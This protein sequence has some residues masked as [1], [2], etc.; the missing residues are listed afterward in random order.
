MFIICVTKCGTN[1]VFWNKNVFITFTIKKFD[2][3]MLI[4]EINYE[5][6]VMGE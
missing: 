2:I 6:Y 3:A 5:I 1:V 4:L